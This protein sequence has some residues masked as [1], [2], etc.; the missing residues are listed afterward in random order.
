MS[1]FVLLAGCS[2]GVERDFILN[3]KNEKTLRESYFFIFENMPKEKANEFSF[4]YTGVIEY[5]MR[6]DE[7][8]VSDG[9]IITSEALKT[10]D[11]KTPDEVI[12][13]DR[14]LIELS[15]QEFYKKAIKEK[16]KFDTREASKRVNP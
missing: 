8:D 1:F 6:K 14:K 11:N 13:I 16:E 10:L 9:M 5:F 12:E 15:K 7:L 3:G 4:A 2:T